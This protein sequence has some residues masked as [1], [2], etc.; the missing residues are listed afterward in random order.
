MS[1]L[2]KEYTN[3]DVTV[4]WKPGVCQHAGVC[5]RSNPLLFQPHA[6]PWIKMDEASSEEIV[7]IVNKCPSGALSMKE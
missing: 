3:G 1:D 2:Q 6:K 7:E 5:V 4:I